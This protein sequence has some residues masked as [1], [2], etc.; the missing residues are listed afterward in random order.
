MKA[1]I[2]DL[3]LDEYQHSPLKAIRAKCLDCCCGQV[4]EIKVCPAVKC[5]LFPYRF[6]KNPFR[7]KRELTQEQRELAAERL[8]K[9]REGKVLNESENK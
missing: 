8:R 3:S 5:P 7:V 1:T 9:A 4:S 6:G 2:S